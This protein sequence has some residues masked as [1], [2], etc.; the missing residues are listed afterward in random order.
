MNPNKRKSIKQENKVAKEMSAKTVV[1]S[2]ALWGAKG[3]VRNDQYLVEC[4]ITSKPF[5]RL[6]LKQWDKIRKEAI[7]DGMRIPVFCIDLEN[8][9]KRFAVVDSSF[10]SIGEV[11]DVTDYV[12]VRGDTKSILVDSQFFTAYDVLTNALKATLYVFSWESFLEMRND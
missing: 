2:G 3:D 8:G 12:L 11:V 7:K 6:S 9:S 4:K 5:F 10:F 1:A